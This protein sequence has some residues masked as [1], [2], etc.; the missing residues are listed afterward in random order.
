MKAIVIIKESNEICYD[1]PDDI[2]PYQGREDVLVLEITKG[3]SL[4]KDKIAKIQDLLVPNKKN[5]LCDF[6]ISLTV[7]LF[8]QFKKEA[9]GDFHKNK[10]LVEKFQ[11]TIESIKY[12]REDMLAKSKDEPLE[13][14][15]KSVEMVNF[16]D[17]FHDLFMTYMNTFKLNA[18]NFH[19][20]D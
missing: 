5:D 7:G 18:I 6:L 19:Y 13:F 10:T 9:L 15:M 1:Y 4:Y 11:K 20:K 8:Q 12:Y 17:C 2:T 14:L 16:M 3:T